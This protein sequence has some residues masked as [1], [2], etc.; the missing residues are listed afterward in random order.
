MKCVIIINLP[1]ESTE[2]CLET[3][4]Y[5][6]IFIVQRDARFEADFTHGAWSRRVQY[7]LYIKR[8]RVTEMIL[9]VLE[10]GTSS[11]SAIL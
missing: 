3:Y 8:L 9:H 1:I 2:M 4:A 6:C 7:K 11:S 5:P 10:N